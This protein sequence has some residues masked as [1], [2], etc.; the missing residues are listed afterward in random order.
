MFGKRDQSQIPTSEKGGKATPIVDSDVLIKDTM[1]FIQSHLKLTDTDH[2][3][4]SKYGFQND[5]IWDLDNIKKVYGKFQRVSDNRK[6]PLALLIT[7][8]MRRRNEINAKAEAD[9]LLEIERE[10]VKNLVIELK[11]LKVKVAKRDAEII[12]LK[13]KI[14]I[15]QGG[16]LIGPESGMIVKPVQSSAPPL[17]E[18]KEPGILAH[19]DGWSDDSDSEA[20]DNDLTTVPPQIRMLTQRR[21]DGVL[22]FNHKP[23][24]PQDIDKWSRDLKHPRVAGMDTWAQIN[25]LKTIYCLH[26][27][28]GV[29]LLA[30]VMTPTEVSKLNSAV[31]SALGGGWSEPG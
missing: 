11:S 14:K 22:Q 18:E 24:K 23:T 29:Q 13:D 2:Y 25:R 15:L 12:V 26:P 28:D 9:R 27:Y 10:K 4:R 8:N 3:I 16:Q 19:N 5:E 6:L 7:Y 1:R 17:Y 21:I 31:T 20:S 30:T